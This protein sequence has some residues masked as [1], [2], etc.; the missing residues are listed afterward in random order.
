MKEAPGGLG[1]TLGG[2]CA[3]SG[4]ALGDG[5][6]STPGLLGNGLLFTA[7]RGPDGPDGPGVPGVPSCSGAAAT[8]FGFAAGFSGFGLL[9]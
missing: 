5:A 3:W 4:I 7:V 1:C 8:G 9:S 2:V 6:D